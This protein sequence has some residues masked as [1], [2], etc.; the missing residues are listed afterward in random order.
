MEELLK[1][2]RQDAHTRVLRARNI[3][4]LVG[5]QVFREVYT[6]C[7]DYT[8]IR[9]HNMLQRLEST[10]LRKLVTEHK[11]ADL[12]VEYWSVRRLRKE[13]S[14]LGIPRYGVMTSY[15]LIESIKEEVQDG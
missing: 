1:K 11:E 14:R 2:V 10:E 12:P 9:I 7:S 15:Q 3:E 4:N 6:H 8:R 13:A 5:T